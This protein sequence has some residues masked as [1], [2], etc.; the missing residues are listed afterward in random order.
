MC[1]YKF[2]IITVNYNN[3]EGLRKT[4]ES[5]VNQTNKNFEYII[6]DGGSTDGSVDVIKEYAE[7]IDY[8]VSEADNG[9]Y[10]AMNKGIAVSKGAYL[11]FMNSGD[12]FYE[13]VT[14]DKV[15]TEIHDEDYV[16][17]IAFVPKAKKT[18][19]KPARKNFSLLDIYHGGQANHQASFIKRELLKD[20]YDATFRI[21]ADD[22][23]FIE[24]VVMQEHTYLP[25]EVI[26][27]EFDNTGISNQSSSR[28]AIEKERN[29]IYGEY[30]SS[31][32]TADYEYIYSMKRALPI[33]KKL[34][35]VG[36][37]IMRYLR[38][39]KK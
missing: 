39:I 16:A 21:I 32:I 36:H 37:L 38:R 27:C 24:K 26:V 22:K 9:I 35:D 8:W 29:L 20:G 34:M 30:F 28:S 5:V 10:D 31:R 1:K 25:I 2:S 3:A 14:L 19:C 6:I 15:A 7:K 23:L 12:C 18:M 11:N 17:G 13:S 4:I 33:T